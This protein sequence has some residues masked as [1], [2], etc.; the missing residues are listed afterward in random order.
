MTLGDLIK[1]FRTENNITMQEFANS[2]NMSK[3]YV[4]ML[5]ANKHPKTGEPIKPSFETLNSVSKAMGIS[6]HE[7]LQFIDNN[8][9][10][11]I[12]TN[13]HPDKTTLLYE[14]K[15]K[16]KIEIANLTK[17][18]LDNTDNTDTLVMLRD[19]LAGV[20]KK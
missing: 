14:G 12:S 10:I 15:D 9:D 8:I 13:N 19:M 11:D 7:L 1:K 4:C 20:C 17:Q 2:A 16:L 18:I 5:E 3:G 6:I